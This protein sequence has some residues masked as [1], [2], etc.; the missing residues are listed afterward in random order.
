MITVMASING[1]NKNNGK[2]KAV[3]V[4]MAKIPNKTPMVMAPLSPIKNLA[5]L[6]LNQ[7]NANTPPI[8]TAKSAA[9]SNLP[10][11]KAMATYGINAINDMPPARPSKPSVS[12]IEKAV[13][14]ITNIKNGIY[15]M[16]RL[17]L[18]TKGTYKTSHSNLK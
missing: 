8:T 6:I 11:R 5:G 1:T 18:P 7:R 2:N 4:Y 15:Q 12:L 3:L 9:K 14:T 17:T 13:P 10:K 16:P